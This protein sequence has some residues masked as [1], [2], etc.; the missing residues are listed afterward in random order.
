M[1]ERLARDY[2]EYSDKVVKS[3]DFGNKCED[4]TPKGQKG[5]ATRKYNKFADACEAAGLTLKEQTAIL[6]KVRND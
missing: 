3:Q 1:L 5:M 4:I 2:T 6:R